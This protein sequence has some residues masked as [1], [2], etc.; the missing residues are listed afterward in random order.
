MNE[1]KLA[2]ETLKAL[3]AKDWAI[4]KIFIYN[5]AYITSIGLLLGN[6]SAL[7]FAWSQKHFGWIKLP[8]KSY[9]LSEVPISIDWDTILILNGIAIS[10]ILIILVLPTL[11]VKKISAIKAIRFD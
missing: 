11:V 2:L 7:A 4:Q 9:Y 5:V 3:G 6:I 8:E 10:C 1:E